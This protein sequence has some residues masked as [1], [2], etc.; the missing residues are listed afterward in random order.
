MKKLWLIG[1][2]VGLLFS[3]GYQAGVIQK[4][5]KSYLQFSGSWGWDEVAVKVDDRE[6]FPLKP[7]DGNTLFEITPGKHALKVFKNN[8]LVVDRIIFVDSQ[9]TFEVRVP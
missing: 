9:A 2:V 1:V 5:E 3:C 8:K 7:T 6:T 4:A